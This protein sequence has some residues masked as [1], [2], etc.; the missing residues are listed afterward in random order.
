MA[1]VASTD[2]TTHPILAIARLDD[3]RTVKY[4]KVR[5]SGSS[6]AND[7]AWQ[8]AMAT[9]IANAVNQTMNGST[10]NATG[11]LASLV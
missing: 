6:Y 4:P 5:P 9:E 8:T 10:K 11:Y 1:T 3:G 7:A 2:T